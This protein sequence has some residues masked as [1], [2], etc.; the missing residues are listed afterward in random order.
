MFLSREDLHRLTGKHRF[1]AQRRALDGLGI[2]YTL[3]ATGEPLVREE[4]LDGAGTPRRNRG[5]RWD[6]L[7][8]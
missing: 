1:S 3:A 6:R 2:R 5:I 7:N 8:V 4:S